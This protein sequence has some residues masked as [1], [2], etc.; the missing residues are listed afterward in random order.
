MSRSFSWPRATG[1]LATVAA[2]V[3]TWALPAPAT[4]A[5]T[6]R[7]VDLAEVV[8]SNTPAARDINL[9]GQ[10]LL[11]DGLMVRIGSTEVQ[12]L[13]ELANG[14]NDL[15]DAV[16]IYYTM[17]SG[18]DGFTAYALRGGV[19]SSLGDGYAT[20]INNAG[21]IVG[22]SCFNGRI[23]GALWDHGTVTDL[24]GP[25]GELST[26]ASDIN[27][28]GQMVGW[29]YTPLGPRNFRAAFWN[30]VTAPV[31]L[32]T[33][34]GFNSEALAL[35]DSA[36]IVGWSQ[37]ANGDSRATMWFNG[38]AVDLGS[39]EARDINNLGQ[40]VGSG[41]GFAATLWE[42][43]KPIDL[44]TVLDPAARAAGFVLDDAMA[45]NDLG[46]IVGTA[47]NTLDGTQHA[48]ALVPA[49]VPEPATLGLWAAGLVGVG[50]ARRRRR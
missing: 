27:E 26:W 44:N 10:V 31:D 25:Y 35:N 7:F 15:G 42:G 37:A 21:Q 18:C 34:G 5:A 45:I 17:G 39:G 43:L 40:I 32:G 48:Y 13:W 24:G 29:R 33:F 47:H 22:Q 3:A 46:W 36:H 50:L 28:R 12:S 2:L 8:D 9:R 30:G 38:A 19:S 4:A 11:R 23:Q 16:G 41:A 20:Q 49:P 14:L 6:Y 1:A